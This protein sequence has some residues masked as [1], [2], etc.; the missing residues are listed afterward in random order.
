MHDLKFANETIFILKREIAKLGKSALS[1]PII[2]N[3]AL[4]PL[5][6]VKPDGFR[7]TFKH[8]LSHEAPDLKNIRLN[9]N[10]MQFDIYC[11]ACKKLSKVSAPTFE[12][13]GCKSSD[14]EFD[15]QKEFFVESIEVE[16]ME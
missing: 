6:H 14:L 7:E 5:S 15:M 13:P 1:K 8:I 2:V 10:T 12:C 9:I 3:V 11:K 16:G 4:S